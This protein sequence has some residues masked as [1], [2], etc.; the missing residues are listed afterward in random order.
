MPKSRAKSMLARGHDIRLAAPVGRKR[1]W[2]RKRRGQ[3]LIT[4]RETHELH[5]P[6]QYTRS[7]IQTALKYA[8]PWAQ[9]PQGQQKAPSRCRA[10][11]LSHGNA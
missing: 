11:G 6:R 3:S 5:A 1:N 2:P 10:A 8:A 4:L 9:S 7:A